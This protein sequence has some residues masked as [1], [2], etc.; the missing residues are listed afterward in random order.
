MMWWCRCHERSTVVHPIGWSEMIGHDLQV[1]KGFENNYKNI[2]N[3]KN[4]RTEDLFQ[5]RWYL[6]IL[7]LKYLKKFED[8][9]WWK[10]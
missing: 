3:M 10:Y 4:A 8:F 9:R 1:K 2:P 6:W 7:S 5:V